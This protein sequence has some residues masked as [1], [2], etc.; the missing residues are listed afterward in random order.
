VKNRNTDA[1]WGP[2]ACVD[3]ITTATK[4]FEDDPD[5]TIRTISHKCSYKHA[6]RTCEVIHSCRLC[7]YGVTDLAEISFALTEKE[8]IASK[9]GFQLRASTAVPDPHVLG[10]ES[11]YEG[12]A[13]EK[14]Y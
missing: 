2:G 14:V 9:L 5:D 3:E 12:H 6:T 13:L 11:T 8:S 4:S 7:K 1:N 10:D